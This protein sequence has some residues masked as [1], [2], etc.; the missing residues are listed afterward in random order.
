MAIVVSTPPKFIPAQNPIEFI[1]SVP[2]TP[3]TQPTYNVWLV[4]INGNA[5][6]C[7]K[8][9]TIGGQDYVFTPNPA[10]PF[11]PF[12]IPLNSNSG[13]NICAPLGTFSYCNFADYITN[14][15]N[16]P[17]QTT[18]YALPVGEAKTICGAALAASV[19]NELV[20]PYI[21]FFIINR[22]AGAALSVATNSTDIS[23]TL[24][25]N[26]ATAY[27]TT[28]NIKVAT[29]VEVETAHNSG[30]FYNL[31]QF[32]SAPEL[33]QAP[34]QFGFARPQDF[35]I[36]PTA[37]PFYFVDIQSACKVYFA[38]DLPALAA[39]YL[40]NN[41]T[42]KV[43]KKSIRTI[44]VKHADVANTIYDALQPTTAGSVYN[45][46][47]EYTI[48]NAR[49]DSYQNTLYKQA[50]NA[51]PNL[52]FNTECSEEYVQPYPL[53][54][55]FEGT[56]LF[57]NTTQSKTIA[58]GD[59]EWLY[60]YNEFAAGLSLRMEYLA[61]YAD[62]SSIQVISGLPFTNTDVCAGAATNGNALIQIP[63]HHVWNFI[64]NLEN[65]TSLCVW[66]NTTRITPPT[67]PASPPSPI[68][69]VSTKYTYT[70]QPTCTQ[71]TFI[72]Q[73]H[74]GQFE[75]I[76]IDVPVQME[77]DYLRDSFVRKENAS[78]KKRT[79]T[80][81]A[82][83]VISYAADLS[84]QNL[85]A[86]NL[87]LLNSP[88]VYWIEKTKTY[89]EGCACAVTDCEQEARK[90]LAILADASIE[91]Y[92]ILAVF[93]CTLQDYSDLLTSEWL[94]DN[95]QNSR[96]Y[97]YGFQCGFSGGIE[98][99]YL[100]AVPKNVQDRTYITC[101]HDNGGIPKAQNFES[102]L[103]NAAV[104]ALPVFPLVPVPATPPNYHVDYDE[105]R[106][107]CG[108]P[109]ITETLT[110]ITI[111]N[112]NIIVEEIKNEIGIYRINFRK[113]ININLGGIDNA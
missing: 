87:A 71:E 106:E 8:K 94:T 53:K 28:Q 82:S 17:N 21:S 26:G 31:P 39:T 76:A 98:Y 36:P 100:I 73:N 104:P 88:S 35:Y 74:L 57:L 29:F 25:C 93:P 32:L 33:I 18:F 109:T 75:T 42:I 43:C 40:P 111:L 66:L 59:Y 84:A 97:T 90:I 81:A 12:I 64:P 6:I 101:M 78:N 10:N 80:L 65:L 58:V 54:K 79:Q 34:E 20:A 56:K 23:L 30:E 49:L 7:N 27:T 96:C 14:A 85:R 68:T 60:F 63:V 13:W 110:P 70:I 45:P 61:T 112:N 1:Y 51:L 91:L 92:N 37:Y 9:I 55:Y 48:L 67:I 105:Y 11:A 5:D 2:N 41:P 19:C 44:K 95:V 22:N 46:N 15:L 3:I 108:V 99:T 113:E 103:P 72:F 47:A 83:N 52:P 16:N 89:L 38:E 62:G 24:V 50:T 86:Q 77:A 102:D 107:R 4:E 69:R